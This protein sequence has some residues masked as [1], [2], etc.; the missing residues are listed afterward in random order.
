MTVPSDFRISGVGGSPFGCGHHATQGFEFGPVILP[1]GPWVLAG[2]SGLW[3]EGVAAMGP[4]GPKH[5]W[6][7]MPTFEAF[8]PETQMKPNWWW[9]NSVT[10]VFIC[11][12]CS[13]STVLLSKFR[14]SPQEKARKPRGKGEDGDAKAAAAAAAPAEG[15][16]KASGAAQAALDAMEQLVNTLAHGKE[17]ILQFDI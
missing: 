6:V 4:R 11:F 10:A 9:C 1:G 14:V 15:E 3:A 13:T 17:E 7:A 16:G 2:R 5:N 12:L 8:Q